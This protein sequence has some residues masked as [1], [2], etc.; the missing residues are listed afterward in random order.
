MA[1]RFHV[2]AD[3]AERIAFAYS[4]LLEAVLSLH[5]L[6][7]PK[8]HAVQHA[9]VRDARRLPSAIRREI[10][11]FAFALRSYFPGFL[12][13]RATGD[14]AAFATELAALASVPDD[15]ITLEFTRPLHGGAL[16]R[17]PAALGHPAIRQ[18][19]LAQA[20]DLPLASQSLVHLA[21]E[22]PRAL[23]DRFSQLLAT[24]WAD[25]FAA[26][27]SRVEPRLAEAVIEAGGVIAGRGLFAQL[28]E[29][30]PE[31]RVDREAQVFWLERA[32]E[33]EVTLERESSLVLTPSVFVWPH[34]RVNCDPPWPLALV[35]PAPAVARAAEPRLLPDELVQLLRALGDDTRLRA[36]RLIAERPRSTQELASLLRFSEAAISKHLR[37]LTEA[38]V[39]ET[40]RESYYV[41]YALKPERIGA[42]SPSLTIFLQRPPGPAEVP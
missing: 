9:F 26:E 19:I 21:L 42:V 13:P 12:Y 27:W 30:A 24:Y 8:H 4:P 14:Y 15:L 37:T 34:V 3:A 25:Y 22:D 39:L 2:A 40:R 33:H 11:A 29:L 35:Y 18:A 10:A 16:P 41:L 17:D 6:T 36:L 28:A 1:I 5:V 23:L 7:E 32:H 31:V 20:T 38:R